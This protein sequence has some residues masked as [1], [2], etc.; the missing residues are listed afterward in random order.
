MPL[1]MGIDGG[2]TSTRAVVADAAGEVRGVGKADGSNPNASGVEGAVAALRAAAEAALA[3]AGARWDDVAATFVGMAGV[4]GKDDEDLARRI[5]VE[6][7]LRNV[8]IDHDIRIAL[9]GGLAGAEGLALIVG[10]GSSCYGRTQDGRS[11]QAGGWGSLLDDGGSAYGLGM[12]AMRAAVRVADGRLPE[13]VLLPRV[14]E[15]LGLSEI[16]QIVRRVYQQ[17][18]SK[19][20]VGQ[21]APVVISAW[22][23]GDAVAGQL[24]DEGVRELVWIVETAGR[25]LGM[26][27]RRVRVTAAGGLIENAASYRER[28]FGALRDALPH[29]SHVG[30]A[31]LAPALGAVLLAYERAGVPHDARVHE[32]LKHSYEAASGDVR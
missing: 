26:L 31:R 9:A 2:G 23:A 16:R 27:E 12:A 15:A 21:L 20:E 3:S 25:R 4:V 32:R 5:A 19:S 6:A 13:S 28:V 17:G 14:M 7:G 24:V 10:T 1:Y 18:M 22:E 30:L 29:G 11:W 8:E